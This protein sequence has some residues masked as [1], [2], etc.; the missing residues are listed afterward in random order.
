M[1]QKVKPSAKKT[2]IKR[3]DCFIKRIGKKENKMH[4]KDEKNV[5]I[6]G[7]SMIK[8]NWYRNIKR[9]YYKDETSSRCYNY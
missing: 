6:I 2:V 8:N 4:G 5:F 3:K 7:D 9:K 1:S